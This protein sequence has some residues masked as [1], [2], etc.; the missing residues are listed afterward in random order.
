VQYHGTVAG[1]GAGTGSAFSLLPAQNATGN[2]IKVVQRVPVRIALDAHELQEHP[3]Q[4]GLS[5]KVNVDTH[6]KTGSTLPRLAATSVSYATDVFH[7]D[8]DVADTRVRDIIASNERARVTADATPRSVPDE[9]SARLASRGKPGSLSAA[10]LG[11]LPRTPV[12][13]THTF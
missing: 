7:T 2:W 3:L 11:R 13:D 5:M 1:F 8:A 9:G 4:I 12:G 6:D 10:S